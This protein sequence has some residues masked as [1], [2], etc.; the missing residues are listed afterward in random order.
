[1]AHW[2]LDEK[3]KLGNIAMILCSMRYFF[4]IILGLD[5][6]LITG[7]VLL[8]LLYSCIK[9]YSSKFFI[10]I[11]YFLIVSSIHF[12]A[13]NFVFMLCFCYIYRNIEISRL[14][15]FFFKLHFYICILVFISLFIGIIDDKI[16]NGHK[17]I[18]HTLGFS[19]PNELGAFM[20]ATLCSFFVGYIRTYK[21]MVPCL[22][23][24]CSWYIYRLSGS[25]TAFYGECIILFVYL[26]QRIFGTKI[27]K[28]FR[29]PISILPVIL[30]CITIYVTLNALDYSELNA[31]FSDRFN[32]I[33]I[34]LS[35]FSSINELI[36]GKEI[37][38]ELLP[39]DNVYVTLLFF[40]G[41]PCIIIFLYLYYRCINR[42]WLKFK[43][44][45]PYLIGLV[46]AGICESLFIGIIPGFLLLW[47]I[48]FQSLFVSKYEK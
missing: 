2:I 30:F 41:L 23:F 14:S 29:I 3:Y 44:Y 32:Y 10:L 22:F 26:I 28:C 17:Q 45:L 38:Y 15:R 9:Q 13:I 31:L 19:N 11:S 24:L 7:V 35:S 40:G 42:L 8:L 36:I 4:G 27:Y 6:Q 34:H 37:E 18:T 33:A 16:D 12:T 46:I 25:R 43:D 39:L 48:V 20:F 1:V 47:I 5:T 21:V